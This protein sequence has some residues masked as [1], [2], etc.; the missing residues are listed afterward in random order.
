MYR[1]R[2]VKITREEGGDV[3]THPG[4]GAEG[5]VDAIHRHVAFSEDGGF[6]GFLIP[7]YFFFCANFCFASPLTRTAPRQ[8]AR[9]DVRLMMHE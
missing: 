4:D 2:G 5:A 6:H 8:A 1:T 9:K 3:L 7:L